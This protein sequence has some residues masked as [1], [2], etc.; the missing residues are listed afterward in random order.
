MSRITTHVL[1]TSRGRPADGVPVAL[2][3]LDRRGAVERVAQATTDA[4]GRVRELLADDA[5]LEAGAYRL[6]FATGA[7]FARHDATTIF[8]EVIVTF[9]VA[10]GAHYHIPL[11]LSPF[12]YTTYRGS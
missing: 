12:G 1:D 9:E 10:G 3:R 2:E 11:L 4:D 8:P 5:P 6:V 7:Y